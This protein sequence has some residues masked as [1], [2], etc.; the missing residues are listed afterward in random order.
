MQ[1][2]VVVSVSRKTRPSETLLRRLTAALSVLF[3]LQAVLFSTAFMLPCF[4]SAL[5]Y[6]W[7]G[8]VSKREYEYTLEDRFLKIDRVSDRGRVRLYEIPADQI[9]LVCAPDAPEALP[10]RKNGSVKVKKEDYTSY[11]DG[12]P[13]YTVL[14]RDEPKPLKLLLDMTPEALRL[15]RSWNREAVRAEIPA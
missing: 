13:Y 7:Y 14:V 8:H 4:L 5:F 12:V 1:D 6:Y 2:V 9:F 15:L 11:R 10:Y 3:L